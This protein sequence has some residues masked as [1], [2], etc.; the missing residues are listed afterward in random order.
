MYVESPV[1]PPLTTPLQ[2][3]PPLRL[4]SPNFVLN[5]EAFELSPT[6]PSLLY[7]NSQ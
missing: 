3:F 5:A 4:E 2:S 6:K 1:A 7:I